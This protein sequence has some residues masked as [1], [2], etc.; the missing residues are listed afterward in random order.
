MPDTDYL[1]LM[2]EAKLAE[3]RPK[4]VFS[5]KHEDGSTYIGTFGM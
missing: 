1:F 5:Y 2:D 4:K 3:L